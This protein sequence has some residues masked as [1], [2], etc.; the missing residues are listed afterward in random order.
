M[1]NKHKHK[2]DGRYIDDY[3]VEDGGEVRVPAY[4]ADGWRGD[5][6]RSFGATDTLDAHRPGFRLPTKFA[7]DVVRTARQEMIDRARSG[8]LMD[9]RR[10]PDDDDDDD[11]ED[12][13][14]ARRFASREVW[15][16]GLQ[17]ASGPI[18]KAH[19]R[20][21]HGLSRAS[22]TRCH[23]CRSRQGCHPAAE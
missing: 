9:K 20:P 13:A 7:R 8:W 23:G 11:D 12:V 14:D 1:A 19:P 3:V 16:R 17:D 2:R 4:L 22:H 18:A 6:V 10:P 5:L 21:S 15:I